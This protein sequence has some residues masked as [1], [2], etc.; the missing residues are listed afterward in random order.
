[1]SKTISKI[2][3]DTKAVTLN[4][5]E[6][7]TYASGIR[8]PIYCD[9]RILMSLPRERKEIIQA[10]LKI[11]EGLEF[12][13]VAGTA[14]AGIPWAAWVAEIYNKPLIYVRSKSKDHGK[15]NLIEGRLDK[16][17]KV[18]VIEDLISTGGSSVS[19][20]EAV[21][22]AGGIVTDCV[23]IFTYE[24]Q[25]AA[26]KF[27]EAKCNIHT[28]TNFSTLANVA[29]EQGHIDAEQR[30]IVL[31]WNKDPEGWFDKNFKNETDSKLDSGKKEASGKKG[32]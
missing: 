8:S 20:V 9:N 13:T 19:A 30:E 22:E 6:P 5:K 16:G 29:G 1:M 27:E 10:F 18:V 14:T 3:L 4:P 12:E 26:A 17:Q 25:K 28:L 32:R 31:E 2:L 15:Q 11:L 7:Y 24:M 21:K 23:A